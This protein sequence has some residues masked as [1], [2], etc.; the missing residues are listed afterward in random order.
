MFSGMGGMK[1]MKFHSES[2]DSGHSFVSDSCV[3][4]VYLLLV[5]R[6]CDPCS[7]CQHKEMK[8]DQQDKGFDLVRCE[9]LSKRCSVD[10]EKCV[11]LAACT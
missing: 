11:C 3:T 1:E 8:H 2:F 7:C 9:G 4:F 10:F 5:D 6:D